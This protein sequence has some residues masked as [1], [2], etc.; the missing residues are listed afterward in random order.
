MSRRF[1]TPSKIPR[2]LLCTICSEVFQHP[3]RLPCGH[4]FCEACI[5]TWLASHKSCPNCRSSCTVRSL[6]PDLIASLLANDLEI[7]CQNKGCTWTGP[8]AE[9][10]DHE[11]IC[12]FH[13]ERLESWM[14][15][16]IPCSETGEDEDLER[17]EGSLLCALYEKY[18]EVVKKA[19]G[20]EA[21]QVSLA[22]LVFGV[23]SDE[24]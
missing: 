21:L 3:V 11:N 13:P 1:L 9:G 23:N 7:V 18:P 24:E 20:H 12:K 19:L 22:E 14:S 10:P 15:T 2:Y 8:L 6:G 16:M 4:T 17:P 5:R